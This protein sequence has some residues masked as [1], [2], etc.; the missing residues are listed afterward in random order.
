[1]RWLPLLVAAFLLAGCSDPAP[2]APAASG[3]TTGSTGTSTAPLAPS[4][5]VV[6]LEGEKDVVIALTGDNVVHRVRV[7]A[8]EAFE[9]ESV[10]PPGQGGGF[11]G[12]GGGG[13]A[14]QFGL[15]LFAAEGGPAQQPPCT[16]AIEFP[17]WDGRARSGDAGFEGTPGVYDLWVWSGEPTSVTLE[18]NGG[19]RAANVTAV[20][21]NWTATVTNPTITKSG[22]AQT[23]ATFD[24][25]VSVAKAALV[26]ARYVP[27]NGYPQETM[28]L[29]VT[30]AGATCGEGIEV[31]SGFGTFA[32]QTL[33]ASAFLGPGEAVV[34]G[35][36]ATTVSPTGDGSA[37]VVVLQPT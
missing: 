11:G 27:P 4:L 8:F 3:T 13:G 32:T 20:K 5:P 33:L 36:Y 22:P 35:S 34:S 14:S 2:N 10:G 16:D 25:P 19:G 37:A 24:H 1:M 21:H 23:T 6:S 31:E 29:T 17:A 18:V 7:V 15:A 30:S 28:S 9:M 26:I 12:G